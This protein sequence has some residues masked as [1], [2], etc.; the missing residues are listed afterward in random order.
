MGKTPFLNFDGKK[1]VVTGASSG[2]GRA[3]SIELSQHG[4]GLILIGRNRERLEETAA[5]LSDG[6]HKIVSLDLTN[7]PEIVPTIRV[8]LEE[9]AL[10]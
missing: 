2:I 5:G 7:H 9:T 4:A 10:E 1:V 3:I 6:D 8:K